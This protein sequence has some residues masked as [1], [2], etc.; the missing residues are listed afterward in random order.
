M[1][2]YDMNKP[3]IAI[4]SKSYGVHCE[5]ALKLL[6]EFANTERRAIASK[7]EMKLIT[8]DYDGIILG[9]EKMDRESIMSSDKLKIIARHGVG[10]DNID[11]DTATKRGIIVTYTPQS[12]ADSVAEYTI[13]LMLN[14][15]KNFPKAGF[16]MLKGNWTRFLGFELMGKIVG[17]IGFGAI[18]RR[19]A[20]KLSGFNVKILAYDPFIKR[21]DF[22]KEGALQVSLD[23]LLQSSDFVTIHVL[24]SSETKHLINSD[25]L[26]LM[27]KSAFL[28]NASRGSIIDEEALY[29]SLKNKEISGAALDVFEEEPITKNNPL[30]SLDNI[31]LSPHMANFTIEA[32]TRMDMMNAEDLKRFFTGE[33]PLYVAN[34][35]VFQNKE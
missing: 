34:P 32:L 23:E 2:E 20:R 10:L 18:G 21:E 33:K 17:I 15:S 19:V 28:I 5:D 12:N 6:E 31:V 9:N 4:T 29:K 35:K 13:M 11:L 26:K 24:L 22:E 16:E 1:K 27:K 30:L 3:N 25:R 8:R 7:D 14:I